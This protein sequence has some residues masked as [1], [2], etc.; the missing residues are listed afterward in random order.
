MSRRIYAVV[1]ITFATTIALTLLLI[2]RQS[3]EQLIQGYG[4]FGVKTS[5]INN[6]EKGLSFLHP[7]IRKCEDIFDDPEKGQNR[8]EFE[9]V[10]SE[11]VKYNQAANKAKLKLIAKNI[12]RRCFGGFSYR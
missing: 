9:H 5:T 10:W 11:L 8:S 7:D 6:L 12:T 1:A 2:S 4:S 3:S